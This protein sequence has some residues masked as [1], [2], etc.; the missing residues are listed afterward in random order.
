MRNHYFSSM[1]REYD[2]R[3]W[4]DQSDPYGDDWRPAR[5]GDARA[6]ID[7]L[8]ESCRWDVHA[9]SA[10][11]ALLL[12]HSLLGM[13]RSEPKV[14]WDYAWPELVRAAETGGVRVHVR[15]RTLHA[16]RYEAPESAPGPVL[17]PS[18]EPEPAND[19]WVA[20]EL[21][22]DGG[23]PVPNERYRVRTPDGRVFEGTLD[24]QGKARVGELAT[25]GACEVTFP[26]LDAR[27]WKAA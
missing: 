16:V 23:D 22:D 11:H 15:E 3:P 26:D 17:G 5:G 2:L 9:L 14:F 10:I 1:R 20:I 27:D 19:F 21:V 7:A 12:P 24:A 13:R 4:I 6:A 8:R 25:A 18:S